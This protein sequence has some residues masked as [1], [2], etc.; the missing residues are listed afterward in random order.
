MQEH[1]K[2]F[3]DVSALSLIFQNPLKKGKILQIGKDFDH[4]F[5]FSTSSWDR[6]FSLTIYFSAHRD[7][8]I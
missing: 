1:E 4:H 7:N 8:C 5:A 2:A 6:V 3:N